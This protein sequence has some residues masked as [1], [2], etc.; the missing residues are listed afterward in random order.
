[1]NLEALFNAVIV[2]PIELEET[3]YGNIVVP[4]LG[5]EKNKTGKIILDRKA[6]I[7]DAA[8]AFLKKNY[9]TLAFVSSKCKRDVGFVI[10]AIADDIIFGTNYKTI[11][12]AITYLTAVA[13]TY[14]ISEEQRVPTIEAYKFVRDQIAPIVQEDAVLLSRVQANFDILTT[15]ISTGGLAT[16]TNY[17]DYQ[18]VNYKLAFPALQDTETSVVN[19]VKNLQA[20]KKFVVAEVIDY[21]K[22]NW[23]QIVIYGFDSDKQTTCGRDIGYAIDAICYDLIYG[24]N[25]QT[26]DAAKRYFN[27]A[28]G[29]SQLKAAEEVPATIDAYGRAQL[30]AQR[31]V[32]LDTIEAAQ[33]GVTQVKEAGGL[34]ATTQTQVNRL[35]A[36]FSLFLKGLEN[37]IVGTSD[38]IQPNG[39]RLNDSD[40]ETA[41]TIV[42]GKQRF[43]PHAAS[44][45]FWKPVICSICSGSRMV[46]MESS[47]ALI[48]SIVSMSSSQVGHGRGSSQRVI[49]VLEISHLAP[50][51]SRCIAVSIPYRR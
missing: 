43:N 2:Q 42:T 49:I 17:L 11:K 39:K 33:A 8:I 9:P 5:N 41:F 4:D 51:R 28:N 31:V 32:I 46:L 3:T 36:L 40:L 20:N 18:N 10:E 37:E 34:V 29:L 25:S 45:I 27:Y 26:V 22:K 48:F 12:A 7:E 14:T 24:G 30:F 44:I 19:L 47:K 35:G 16:L 1:M 50:G 23:P 13:N 21:I 6:Q 38:F 15:A